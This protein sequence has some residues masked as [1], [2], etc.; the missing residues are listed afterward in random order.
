MKRYFLVPIVVFL[1][2]A[3]SQMVLAVDADFESEFADAERM[4]GRTASGAVKDTDYL[5]TGTTRV[6]HEENMAILAQID[7]LHKEI[8]DLKKEIED[9]REIVEGGN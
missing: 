1:F 9:V 5:V 3:A 6:L 7:K 8:A 4:T 2:S